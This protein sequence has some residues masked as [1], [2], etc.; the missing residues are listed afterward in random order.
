MEARRETIWAMRTPI[1]MSV[2]RAPPS[3]SLNLTKIPAGVTFG[4]ILEMWKLRLR[5]EKQSAKAPSAR[6]RDGI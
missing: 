1:V 3:N 4:P 6:S 5:K 2:Y